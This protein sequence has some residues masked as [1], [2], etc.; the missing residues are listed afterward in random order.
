M[1][2]INIIFGLIILSA[3]CFTSCSKMH[4]NI[5]EFATEETVYPG[6][7]DGVI[8]TYTGFER[9]ELDLMRAGRIPASEMNLGKAEKTVVE[10]GNQPLVIDS[11]ASWVNVT[12]LKLKQNYRFKVYTIDKY[13]DKSI[14]V[15]GTAM[16]YLEDDLNTLALPAQRLRMLSATSMEVSWMTRMSSVLLNYYRMT[17]S[18]TDKDN[19]K[20]EGASSGENPKIVLENLVAGQQVTFEWKCRIIPRVNDV[21]IIDSIWWDRPAITFTMPPLP[22]ST[23]TL[24]DA[25]GYWEFENASNPAQSIVGAPLVF[26]EDNKTIT[27]ITG[28]RANN[29]AIRIPRDPKNAGVTGTFVKCDHGLVPKG[30]QTKIN[31]YTVMWDIRLPDEE[32]L[33]ES[34]YYSLMSARALDNSRDQ[35][36]AIKK[37]GS[38][39]IG[40]LGY[41]SEGILTKGRWHRIILSAKAGEFFRYY[42]DGVR[43][44]NGNAASGDAVI[45]GRF[46][47]LP[48]G[49]LFFSDE[50]GD[51]STIDAAAIAIWDVALADFDV[52]MLGAVPQ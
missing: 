2:K 39:G 18:Y 28:P 30:G 38:F 26:V 31:E 46:S 1:K 33:P 10:Y 35:D 20:H 4:D 17:Y 41:S 22:E 37:A 36:F 25:K 6:R 49:V 42:L 44:Y 34:G 16:P 40:S 27:S 19:V 29:K 13:N 21:P 52:T 45:D 12:G 48:E 3:L 47:L 24:D 5:K 7:L 9:V 11:V 50:D 43:V 8:R 15:E 32:G 51:D 23:I 14:A